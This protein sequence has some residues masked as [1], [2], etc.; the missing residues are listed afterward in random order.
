[1]PSKSKSGKGKYAYQAKKQSGT[2]NVTSA[3]TAPIQPAGTATPATGAALQP[4]PAAVQ[5]RPAAPRQTVPRS[6]TAA[7]ATAKLIKEQ[8]AVV[9]KELKN[10]G[11]LVSIIIVVLI[12]L[13]FVLK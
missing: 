3:G 11:I 5:P 9:K 7:A 2:L 12:A 8:G 13:V 4:R 1:M 6:G 10:I